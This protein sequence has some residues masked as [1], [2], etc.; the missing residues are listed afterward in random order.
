MHK[1]EMIQGR[2][3]LSLTEMSEYTANRPHWHTVQDVSL[4]KT[5]RQ[6]ILSN[7]SARKTYHRQGRLATANSPS[8]PLLHNMALRECIKINLL[9][10]TALRV[11]LLFFFHFSSQDVPVQAGQGLPL[12]LGPFFFFSFMCPLWQ[13]T[14]RHLKSQFL[15]PPPPFQ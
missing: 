7:I 14:H 4:A 9:C 5:M 2:Y 11:L 13:V 10:H 3:H 1:Q 6:G 12:H 8:I 15:G